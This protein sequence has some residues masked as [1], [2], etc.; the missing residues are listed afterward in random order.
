MEKKILE[1][2]SGIKK[3]PGSVTVDIS[4]EVNPD[5]VH[6]L[7]IYPYPF[8]DNEFDEI[9]CEDILLS[10]ENFFLT[11]KEIHRILKLD[12]IVKISNPYFRSRYA[13]IHPEI[14]NLF[15]INSFN[16]FNKEHHI[17]RKYK[18]VNFIFKIEKM[19][20]NENTTHN[21]YSRLITFFANKWPETY[22]VYLSHLF[23][24]DTISWV[25]IKKNN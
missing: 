22:E 5:I 21:W 15:S 7:N 14:K 10:L 8:L 2:G 6:D 11:M 4:K 16:F 20:F 18:Y 17:F 23:P 9:Y 25:L 13:Y 12:G 3:R 1:I 19:T 24:L